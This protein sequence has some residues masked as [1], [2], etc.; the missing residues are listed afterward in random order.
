M[1]VVSRDSDLIVDLR[2]TR[3]AP[4]PSRA[5]GSIIVATGS[6]SHAA[7]DS[8]GSTYHLADI[9]ADAILDKSTEFKTDTWNMGANLLLGIPSDTDAIYSGAK[10]AN[11]KPIVFGSAM[12]GLPAWQALGLA[13]RPDGNILSIQLTANGNA[14]AAGSAKFEI[15][16]RMP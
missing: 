15:A 7:D 16:Y 8:S 9:P 4:D 10:G 12:H 14:T 11:L 6:V 3:N 2:V 5:R 13:A 1:P